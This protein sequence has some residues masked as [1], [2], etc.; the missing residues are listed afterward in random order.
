MGGK[1]GCRHNDDRQLEVVMFTGYPWVK[2]NWPVPVPA[3]DQTRKHGDGNPANTG[4]G[5]H[6]THGFEKPVR[7]QMTAIYKKSK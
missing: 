5:A 6:R 2:F 7:V 4:T 3:R 1:W